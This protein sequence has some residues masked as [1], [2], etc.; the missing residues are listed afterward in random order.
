MA[1]KQVNM[2]LDLADHRRV[3]RAAKRRQTRVVCRI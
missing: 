1:T 2:R 3:T